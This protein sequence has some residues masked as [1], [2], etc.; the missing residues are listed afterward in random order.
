MPYFLHKHRY[1][2]MALIVLCVIGIF[3][4]QM[5]NDVPAG[6]GAANNAHKLDQP[7]QRLPIG[8]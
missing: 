6:G 1:W 7:S 5:R 2:F 3:W 4:F 8:P